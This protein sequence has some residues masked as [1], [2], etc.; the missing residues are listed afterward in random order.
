[1]NSLSSRVAAVCLG[2]LFTC[3]A[4]APAA[5]A[6]T[7]E[8]GEGVR[9]LVPVGHT[10]G[11]KLFADGVLVVGLSD[12]DTPAKESGLKEG[13]I[14]LAFNGTDIGSTEHLQQLLAENGEARATMSV[15]RGA[16][17]LTLPVTPEET[18]DG[19]YRLGAWI[20]DSMAGI[21]T[22]TF[23]DPQS[24]VFGALGHGVTD[25]DTGK[26]MPLER[27]SIMDA[28]VKAVK[29]GES[30]SPG[31][32]RGDFDLTRDSGSLC[33]NT[34]CG[35]F[36]RLE[37]KSNA[38][39]TQKAVPV[40]A[41]GEIKTGRATILANCD[42]DEV[43]EYTV[44][45]ERVYPGASPTR[46]LLVRVTDPALLEQTGGIVQGMSGSPILQ[47]GKLVGAVTHVLVND[48]AR[49]YGIFIE[50]MLDAAGLTRADAG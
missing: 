8:S 20:R 34:D 48:A 31:E 33:A 14:V 29:R 41:K 19:A 13:D 30:G 2:L 25:V 16:K 1:M 5:R 35:L 43:R 47:D 26:L 38:V 27:G 50:N 32:L 23:Y 12:G 17:T 11:V 28:T 42:G 39:T 37:G 6:M 15:R 21:G 9:Y 49:G 45:I 4:F 3:A 24:G 46:N 36:G 7:R 40:A 10:V 22:M 18:G 44:E